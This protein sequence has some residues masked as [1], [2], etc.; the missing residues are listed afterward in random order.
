MFQAAIPYI[1]FYLIMKCLA[2]QSTSQNKT[3]QAKREDSKISSDFKP[4]TL[5][6]TCPHVVT[7]HWKETCSC[8]SITECY[9]I[10]AAKMT[11]GKQ[12]EKHLSHT[13]ESYTT[14]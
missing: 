4:Q 9:H 11:I 14:L 10:M 5:G 13:F 6:S 7:L 2:K 1:Q 3:Q 12:E 8:P